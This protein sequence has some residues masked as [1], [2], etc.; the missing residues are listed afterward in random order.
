[1]TER[2]VL[3]AILVA[4]VMAL[5]AGCGKKPAPAVEPEP[6]QE[7]QMEAETQAAEEA[8]TTPSRFDDLFGTSAEEATPE[9]P[10]SPPPRVVLLADVHFE[11][12]K[13]SLTTKARQ[14]LSN[15]ARALKENPTLGIQIE[16]HCDERGTQ[17][18]NLALGQ[19]RAQAAKDYL[20]NFGIDPS[21][22]TI[23][24][25][26]EERPLDP[27]S[28]EEAWAKNRRAHFRKP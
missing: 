6:P 19:R 11:F 5:S 8:E 15:H 13:F 18:Y 21:R 4:T 26:G 27:G 2:R 24:S 9:V 25:Y 14:V 17:E 20:A 10:E 3:L 23:I 7:P 22:I 12:D 16:G 1:M 28:N